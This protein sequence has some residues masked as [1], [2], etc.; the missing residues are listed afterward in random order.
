M[1]NKNYI[2]LNKFSEL[3]Y[4]FFI[5]VRVGKQC[6]HSRQSHL[7]RQTGFYFYNLKTNIKNSIFEQN[8]TW[9]ENVLIH[10]FILNLKLRSIYQ[11]TKNEI[12]IDVF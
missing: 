2:F 12:H 11:I 3:L 5:A 4:T 8:Y 1:N 7:T 6:V 10:F 9:I